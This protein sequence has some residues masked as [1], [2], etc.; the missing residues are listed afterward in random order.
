MPHFEKMLYDQA[1][2]VIGYLEAY[3]LTQRPHYLSVA[4]EI[5]DYVMNRLKAHELPGFYCAEDAD[6]DHQEGKTYLWTLSEVTAVLGQ[7]DGAW[8]ADIFGIT[9]DGNAPDEATGRKTGANVFHQRKSW[10][11]L[12]CEQGRHEDDLLKRWA[13]CRQRL[14][15]QRER[16]RQ[17]GIDTKLLADWNAMM[18]VALARLA[19]ISRLYTPSVVE[20]AEW[21]WDVFF[22]HGN[23]IYHSFSDGQRLSVGF[24]SDAAYGV[25]G[26]ILV[27]QL[28]LDPV[29]LDRAKRLFNLAKN[30]F[31]DGTAFCIS[32]RSDELPLRQYDGVDSATPSANSVFYHVAR[33]LS[34]LTFEPEY[35]EIADRLWGSMAEEIAKHPAAYGFWLAAACGE[36]DKWVHLKLGKPNADEW[37]DGLGNE[38]LP[39]SVWSVDPEITDPGIRM[40]C[41]LDGCRP[42]GSK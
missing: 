25:W 22:D 33:Q 10:T 2:L 37:R 21:M 26:F 31:W 27:H 39:F 29:Y 15:I 11:E 32:V 20:L 18:L 7:A 40:V 24:S 28:T 19:L 23:D 38:F 3:Q 4:V 16:R 5:V 17:P 13:D 30:R 12:A 1:M 36:T 42:K 9:E 35:N 41:G 14:R 8:V 34:V 6:T